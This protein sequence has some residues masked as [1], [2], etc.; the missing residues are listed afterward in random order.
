MMTD[1]NKFIECA[2]EGDASYI[3]TGDPHFLSFMTESSMCQVLCILT[4]IQSRYI[5]Q[6]D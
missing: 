3:V 1:D 2:K 5:V 6:I 4:V